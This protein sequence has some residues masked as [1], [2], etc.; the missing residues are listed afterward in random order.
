MIV[1]TDSSGPNKDKKEDN[2]LNTSK[3]Y[4]IFTQFIFEVLFFL[5]GSI[6]LGLYL[7]KLLQTRCLFLIVFVLIF[8]F[9]PIYNLIKRVN[10]K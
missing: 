2:N 5:G 9:V 6:A 4:V 1:V 8:S 3:G 7:D 10:P